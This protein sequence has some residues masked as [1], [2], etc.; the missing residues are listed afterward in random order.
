MIAARNFAFRCRLHRFILRDDNA[1]GKV[2][3]VRKPLAFLPFQRSMLHAV[4]WVDTYDSLDKLN[5]TRNNGIDQHGM[6]AA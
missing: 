6:R 5:E 4:F 3:T 1:S 2:E